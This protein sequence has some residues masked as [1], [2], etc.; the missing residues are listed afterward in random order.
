MK[1]LSNHSIIGTYDS[2]HQLAEPSWKEKN[3]S[4]YVVQKL[5]QAGIQIKTFPNH[6]G[7]IA[8][9]PGKTNEVIALRADLDALV[10]EVNG[11]VKA[12]HSCGH[13]AHST[14][15]LHTALYL[16]ENEILPSKTI[17]FIF[18]PAEEVGGGALQMIQDGA[19][20]KV[21]YLFGIHVR[22]T[23]ELPYGKAAAFIRHQA[24]GTIL[25]KI[26]GLQAHAARPQ[27]GI[28]V[29]E[30]ASAIVQSLK[31]IKI[32]TPET[33]SVKM[34]QLKTYNHSTNIIPEKATFALDIRAQSN[35]LM[36]ELKNEINNI[37]NDIM[38]IYKS[39][40]EYEMTDYVPASIPSTE[41]ISI[42][43]QAI[44]EVLGENN[45]TEITV[46]PGGED[47]HFYPFKYPSI[48]ATMIGLG[49]DLLPGLHHPNMQFNVDALTYGT[50]ILIRT[51]LLAC[52]QK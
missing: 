6:F 32:S 3:T 16:A 20:D 4:A 28:N 48:H 40:I 44:K 46:S 24:A 19:L 39:T 35:T 31:G 23:H 17:R 30:S 1:H 51:L 11:T 7:I 15:V 29:I 52:E 14:M 50:H 25:G 18:Q 5:L 37:V 38:A 27:D 9:I 22:P 42:T 45:M 21:T 47:F 41:A 26:Q 34:T 8:E 10:Q 33:Y 12:N 2:L 49:C 13:D 43:K 36:E